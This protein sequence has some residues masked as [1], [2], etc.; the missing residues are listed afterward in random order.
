MLENVGFTEI[1]FYD[2]EDSDQPPNEKCLEFCCV[3]SIPISGTDDEAYDKVNDEDS[4]CEEKAV[5]Y[6]DAT[7]V[8]IRSR[9]Y[10]PIRSIAC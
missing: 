4:P 9:T 10:S 8:P 2:G 5:V 7:L 1:R 6:A 3:F